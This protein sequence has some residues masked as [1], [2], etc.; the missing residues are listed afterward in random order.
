METTKKLIK[1]LVLLLSIRCRKNVFQSYRHA[2]LSIYRFY[3]YFLHATQLISYSYKYVF[4]NI[5]LYKKLQN[6]TIWIK[7]LSSNSENICIYYKRKPYL[8]F[9]MQ[10]A[11][12]ILICLLDIYGF[13]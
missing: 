9:Q 13:D 10:A 7:K 6:I 5:F 2:F 12:I 11:R 8:I 4:H 3:Y 1:I